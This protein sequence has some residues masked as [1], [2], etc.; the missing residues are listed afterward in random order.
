MIRKSVMILIL[1]AMMICLTACQTMNGMG[2]AVQGF[3]RDIS[4]VA[5]QRIAV[6]STEPT[7]YSEIGG[8]RIYFKKIDDRYV[9][10]AMH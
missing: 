1:A 9:R 3:G 8:D 5:K 10:V 7:Y 6:Y 4:W 2:S